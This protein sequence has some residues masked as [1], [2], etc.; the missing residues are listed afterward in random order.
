MDQWGVNHPLEAELYRTAP[1]MAIQG[2]EESIEAKNRLSLVTFSVLKSFF[3]LSGNQTA[4]VQRHVEGSII[5]SM[6]LE[7][8]KAV[9]G[10]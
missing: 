5:Y 10:L 3:C 4:S 6:A 8:V 7:A 1:F 9:G 2:L